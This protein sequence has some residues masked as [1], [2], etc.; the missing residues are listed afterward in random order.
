MPE[1]KEMKE[2][3]LDKAEKMFLQFGYAKVTME[4][5]ASGLGI[6][7][8]TLY[9][10][11]SSK[12]NL[13]RELTNNRICNS[14]KQIN[15]IWAEEGL[16]FVGKLKKMLD[17]IGKESSKST[18]PLFEDIQKNIP[19]LWNIIREYKKM[20]NLKK[21]EDIFISGVENRVFRNDI[22]KD[23]ILLMFTSAVQG[24]VNPETLSQLPYSENQAVEAIF[25]ILFEGILTEEGRTKYISYK[26]DDQAIKE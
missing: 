4:E 22:G 24:I 8:K 25:K 14:E 16:D 18:G 13:V 11:F 7:K 17:F 20:R 3:I 10:F 6:S 9:K 23:I 5:I 26:N 1:E 2:R 15:K 21:A 12:E 19:D